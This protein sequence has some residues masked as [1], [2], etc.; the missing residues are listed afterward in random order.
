MQFPPPTDGSSTAGV[1]RKIMKIL[2]TS[3]DV[4]KAIK[5]V[6]AKNQKR[7][8]AVV[9]YLGENAEAFLP[10]PKGMQIICCPEPG[11]TSPSSVRSLIARGAEVQFSDDLHAKVYWSEGGCVIASANISNRALGRSN[12]K[13][14]GVLIDSD[15]FDIDRLINEVKPH[16]ITQKDM[17]RLEKQDRK[18]KRAIGVRRQKKSEKHFLDWHN[19]PYKESW[20]IGWWSESDLKTAKSAKE[21]AKQEYN[22]SEPFGAL[23]VSK[24]QVQENDWLL[25]FEMTTNGIKNIEWM[26]V[27]FVVYVDAKDTGAYEKE[28]PYQAIQIHKSNQYPEPPFTIEKD[29]RAAFKKS[30]RDYGTDKIEN[31]KRLVPPKSLIN[32]VAKYLKQAKVV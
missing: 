5:D 29:F 17:D 26:Y 6:F 28:Y 13:E 3:S 1:I 30:V 14:T 2:Y 16:K 9:A 18:I 11:A 31:I 15:D 19:S 25:C 8:I 12:Q 7:R 23:N 20:K 32:N 27:D 21:R 10:A 4:H 24:S 22:V